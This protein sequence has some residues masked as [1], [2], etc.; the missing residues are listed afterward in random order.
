MCHHHV[1]EQSNYMKIVRILLI[2]FIFFVAMSVHTECVLRIYIYLFAYVVAGYDIVVKAVKNLVKG[3][4][5]DENFLMSIA[6]VGA[7]VIKEYPEAVMVMLLYQIGEYF[8]DKAVEKSRFSISELMNIRPDFANVEENNTIVKKKPQKVELGNVI[9]VMPGEKIPLDGE[10]VFGEG[11]VDTSSLTGESIPRKLCVGDKAL[12]GCVNLDSML[13]IIV[14]KEYKESTVAK[15]LDLVE[16]ATSKK[17][18]T[19]KFITKF[20]KYYTPIVVLLAIL[21]VIVPLLFIPDANFSVWFKR[22]LTFLVISCPCAL[23]ISIPL[24]FFAGIG[25]ASKQGVLVKGSNYL[26]LLSRPDTVLFDKTGTLTVGDFKVSKIYSPKMKKEKLLEYAALAENFSTHPIA[27]SIRTAYGKE[28]DTNRVK[29]LIEIAGF[30]IKANIDGEDI[31]VGNLKLMSKFNIFPFNAEDIGNI[32]Y[33]AKNDC[34]L[35]YIVISD[36]IKKDSQNTIKVLKDS[37]I[38]TVILTGDVEKN[39]KD[40]NRVLH[41]DEIFYELLPAEKIEKLEV[42]L[43]QKVQKKSVIFVGDGINDA[44]ALVRADVGIAMGGL[45]SDAAIEAADVVIMDDNPIKIYKA[46]N[47]AKNTIKI[48]YQNIIFVLGVKILFLMFGALGIISIW[49]AVFAD[50]GI[51][52][53]AILNALRVLRS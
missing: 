11:F 27:K 7:F 43:E 29:E 17:A 34:C 38:K 19:E 48:V 18:K 37:K 36:E 4:L 50:T 30:G 40:V 2:I 52:F 10:V 3:N 33:V 31:Y 46:I 35:G 9:V 26:E 28:V 32:V 51:T 24:T 5:F 12:S 25:A 21:L 45:G 13:K 22:A 23:V 20:A 16:N 41:V 44:P 14:E 47:I 6:T 53:I 8:Q 42:Y 1:S 39:A 49:G 15:I